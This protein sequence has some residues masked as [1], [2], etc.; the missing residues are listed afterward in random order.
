MKVFLNA[1][2]VAGLVIATLWMASVLFVP[3]PAGAAITGMTITPRAPTTGDSITIE[4]TGYFGDG[5]WKPPQGQCGEVEGFEIRPVIRARDQWA[6]GV[7]CTMVMV[8][9]SFKCQY[10]PLEAGYYDVEVLE[11]HDSIRDPLP[12]TRRAG[13]DVVPPPFIRAT[14]DVYPKTLNL[15]SKG[16]DITSYVE[17]P[18]GYEPEAIDLA[19]V[20]FEHTIGALL[21][22]TSVGD[23]DLDGVPDRMIKFPRGEVVAMLGDL[24]APYEP[25]PN[26]PDVGATGG[27][28]QVM[29]VTVS[30]RLMDG[31]EFSG[32]DSIHVINPCPHVHARRAMDVVSVPGSTT[33]VIRLDLD[34]STHLRV[35]IYDVT[36]KPVRTLVEES[37][38]PG[39]HDLIWDGKTDDGSN[40]VP[41]A[42]FVRCTAGAKVG[43]SKVV[44]V[45]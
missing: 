22:P 11:E 31:T 12:E 38:P 34:V 16:K 27:A 25:A 14:V 28:A 42:Y 41:G 8:P 44:I 36:G 37:L 4:V 26:R 6:P 33:G 9:Y 1:I 10:G 43:T 39:R 7:V 18:E 32:V 17:L 20:L 23:H 2:G 5:C 40:V 30:G 21:E 19:T 13:F 15:K 24:T 29:A 45:R 35:E 3:A